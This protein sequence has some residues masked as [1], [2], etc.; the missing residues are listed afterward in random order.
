MPSPRSPSRRLISFCS[1]SSCRKWTATK[2][3]GA[4]K[5][6]AA[7]CDIP[8][9]FLSALH[10]TGDKLKGFDIG[11]VD[12]ITKPFQAEEVLARVHTHAQLRA[13]QGKLQAEAA[14]FRVLVE[15]ACEGIVL[16]DEGLILDVNEAAAALF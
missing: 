14:R 6:D 13:L 8:V 10:D 2:C 15:A 4:L 9:I 5:A 12:Y 11:G 1:T 16:H 3:A 7:T